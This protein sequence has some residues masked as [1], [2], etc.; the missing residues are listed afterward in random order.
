MSKDKPPVN[1]AAQR[2]IG[3]QRG[4]KTRAGSTPRYGARR[5]T[6]TATFGRSR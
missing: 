3:F 1:D 4:R 5:S 2:G 6:P